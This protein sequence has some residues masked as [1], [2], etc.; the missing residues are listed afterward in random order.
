[1]KVKSETQRTLGFL[2]YAGPRFRPLL[3]I[4]G[5]TQAWRVLR[6]GCVDFTTFASLEQTWQRLPQPCLQAVLTPL[7]RPVRQVLSL[8]MSVRHPHATSLGS[9]VSPNSTRFQTPGAAGHGSRSLVPPSTL[10]TWPESPAPGFSPASPGPS[11]ASVM[12]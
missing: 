10:D 11:K 3:G 8:K 4:P 1:M 9:R 6:V 7:R 2:A 5:I 12:E